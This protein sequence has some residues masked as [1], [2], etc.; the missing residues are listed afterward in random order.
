MKQYENLLNK[1]KKIDLVILA[2]GKGTRI[3]EKLKSLPKPMVKFQKRDFLQYVLNSYSKFPFRKI[4]IL[5]GYRSKFIF[6]KYHN[7]EINFI[8]IECLKEEKLLGTGGS[9]FKLKNKLNDFILTNGDSLFEI[10][11]S[12]LINSCRNNAYGSIALTKNINQGSRKLNRLNL[13]KNKV[14]INQSGKLMNGG[15]YFFKRKIFRF[16]ENK[17]MSLENDILKK[18]L[19]EGKINGIFSNTLFHDIG[20][21]KFFYKTN[22]LINK[23]LTRPAAFLDRDGVI[24]FDKKYIFKMNDFQLRKGVI[25]GIKLLQKK[26]F[27]L[28][29]VTN[30]AGIAKK[31]FTESKFKKFS[32]DI[33]YFFFKK[34]IFFNDVEY[35]PYH[36]NALVKKY[37][38]DSQLRKPGNLMIKK[39][40]NKWPIDKKKSFFIGD[41][42]T[43]FK[44]AKKSNLYFEYAEK[45]FYDQIKN[46]INNY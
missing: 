36:K 19:D 33:K 39:I 1:F 3:K 12:R 25:K 16:I 34:K 38:K 41:Q 4:Y 18:L 23:K 5:T 30:Q 8:K 46:L 7:K 6:K 17:F 28:F 31:K 29:I 2:G 32:L 26:N 27:Y 45:N 43:D 37:K 22:E 21:K 11:L 40:F 14:I 13:K 42:I 9:L 20:T 15:V 24:N 10:D 44:C 35:C